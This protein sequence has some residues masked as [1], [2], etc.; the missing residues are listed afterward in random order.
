MPAHRKYDWETWFGQRRTRLVRGQD[1]HCSQSMMWQMVRNN[2]Y[3]RGLVG[4]VKITDTH[5]GIEIEVADEVLH[6]D[7]APVPQ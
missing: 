1:Y 3:A 4:R 7:K 6:P 5:D 2:A